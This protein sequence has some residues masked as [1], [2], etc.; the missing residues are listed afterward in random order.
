MADK[1]N[2]VRR[3]CASKNGIHKEKLWVIHRI[4]T[5]YSYYSNITL[6]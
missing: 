1:W 2:T 5:L 6:W 3:K 4:F